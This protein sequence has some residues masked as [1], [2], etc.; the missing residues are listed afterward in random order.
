MAT[1][2][3]AINQ[4]PAG[5]WS[6]VCAKLVDMCVLSL[7][8]G[9]FVVLVAIL[10]IGRLP[11]I[12]RA[13]PYALFLLLALGVH[14]AIYYGYLCSGGRQTVGYRLAGIKVASISGRPVGLLRSLWRAMLNL[15][16]WYLIAVIVGV[17][18]YLIVGVSRS[19]RAVHDVLSGTKVVRVAQPKRLSL[20]LGI[21]GSLIL[22]PIF[23]FLVLRPLFMMAFY[24]PSSA[25]SPT[26]MV[27][28]RF[29]ANR[30]YYRV[31]APER[32]DIVVFK[33]P[34]EATNDGTEKDFIKRVVGLPGDVV[35]VKN[36]SLYRNGKRLV[37]TYLLEPEIFYG[38]EPQKIPRGKLFLM[39]DN[40]NNSNDSHAWGPLE[41][42]RLA[43]KVVFRY[44]PPSRLGLVR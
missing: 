43:G 30:L 44:W 15:L 39:G 5:F 4:K 32:G 42:E 14:W 8:A 23:V 18:A 9:L 41:C 40:R 29:L 27:N 11:G 22:P 20:S 12:W 25:M 24:V 34:P 1:E 37:E 13:T 7:I 33:A 19:K 28:D 26:L 6:R 2:R 35:E 36:G 38:M 16:F 17:A 10:D 3:E 31:R 21:F